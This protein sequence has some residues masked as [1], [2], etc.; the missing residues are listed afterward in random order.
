MPKKTRVKSV[1]KYCLIF[2]AIGAFI[3]FIS[4]LSYVGAAVGFLGGWFVGELFGFAASR[5]ND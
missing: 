1:L 3:G 2:G 5:D 4:G